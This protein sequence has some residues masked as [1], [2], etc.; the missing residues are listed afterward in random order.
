MGHKKLSYHSESPPSCISPFPR[1]CCKT[2]PPF[3]TTNHVHPDVIIIGTGPC[4]GTLAYKLA[5]SGK[6]ILLVECGG[7]LPRE[8]DNWNS[9]TV[10]IDNKYKAKE[11]WKD[12]GGGA[13]DNGHTIQV[14]VPSSNEL[15][16]NGRTYYLSQVHFHDPREHHLDGRTYPMEIHLVHQDR[17]GHVVVIGVLVETGSPNQ[18]L[19]ELWAMLP[20]K[21]GELGAEHPF[22]PQD[23]VPHNTHHFSY[24]G[25]LTTPRCT[26]GVHWIVLHDPISMSPRKSRSSSRSLARMP[27]LSSR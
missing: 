24:H 13:L 21:E 10:F 8:K 20:M 25:S 23:L 3:P 27:V 22:N 4:G 7:Y 9:K 17:K 26:E 5:L 14:N 1:H 15:H 16:L 18:S 12:K 19:A 6:K 11:T 2:R